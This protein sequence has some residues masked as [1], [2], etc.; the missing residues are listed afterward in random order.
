MN[1][2]FNPIFDRKQKKSSQNSFNQLN[3]LF[4]QN[5][6]SIEINE[7]DNDNKI[8]HFIYLKET[9]R[10]RKWD[11]ITLIIF[12]T[13]YLTIRFLYNLRLYLFYLLYYFINIII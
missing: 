13:S 8:I 6:N 7:Q 11:I 5:E 2:S 9:T 3:S 4:I 1:S 12:S 10:V